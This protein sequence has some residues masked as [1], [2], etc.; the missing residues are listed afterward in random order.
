MEE[1]ILSHLSSDYPWKE[2]FHYLEETDSTND[3]LKK[4]ARQGAPHGTVLIADRQSSGH[5]RMGRSFHSPGGMGI[6]F[7]I[8]LRPQCTPGQLMHLTC[9]T[10]VAMCDAVEKAAGFRPGIKWTNDLVYKKRKLGGILTELGF[11]SNGS[12]DYAIIGIGINCCQKERDFAEDI[13]HIAASLSMV[14][15]KEIDRG[16]IAAAM[17]DALFQMDQILLTQR[18]DI[19]NRYRKDCITIGQEVSVLRVGEEVRH[20]TAVDM[21]NHGA[22]VVEFADGHREAINSGEVS[23]RGM[24]G[25]L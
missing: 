12:V 3:Q 10:A 2:H 5:G 8:L 1:H 9:A 17:M 21:D 11:S 6:Y 23:I 14:T 13:R 25:Y 4:M 24:Y 20:G 15:G 7:S 18:D 22:L 16:N 19:L